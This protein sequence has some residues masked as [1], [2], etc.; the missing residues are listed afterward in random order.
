MHHGAPILGHVVALSALCMALL[1]CSDNN[2]GVALNPHE[3][4]VVRSA[5]AKVEDPSFQPLEAFKTPGGYPNDPGWDIYGWGTTTRGYCR[6]RLMLNQDFS[7]FYHYTHTGMNMWSES[8]MAFQWHKR[9]SQIV[10]ICVITI[11]G[12]VI[13]VLG[14]IRRIETRNRVAA[15]ESEKRRKA[16]EHE[17]N[18]NRI[19][20]NLEACISTSD[21]CIT[22]VNG[23]N[24]QANAALDVAEQEFAEGAFAPFWDAVE[25]AAN[26][27][28]QAD[29]DI[30]SLEKCS[31]GFA[32][33]VIELE[34]EPPAFR[35]APKSIPNTSRTSARMRE[36]VRAAQRN[37]EFASIYEQRKTNQLLIV[38][39]STLNEALT[40]MTGRL[41]ESIL[42]LS[43]S[44]TR[45]AEIN[46]STSEEL[47]ES[48]RLLQADVKSDGTAQRDHN[49]TVEK[50][51]DNIQRGR[52]PRTVVP[53]T[54][55]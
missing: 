11:A 6:F 7:R 14:H 15:E 26:R 40:T 18:Q 22:S 54:F 2:K 37:F 12:F 9:P 13:A 29:A 27:L 3:M 50:I 34:S 30:R 45:L 31:N 10:S 33:E 24:E 42:S 25:R 1:G 41:E 4:A 43:D 20:Q 46:R 35:F 5:L 44:I 55:D 32:K 23:N 17:A 16:I 38:G 52:K 48:V 8:Y 19:R 28:A 53:K 49:E 39:F 47:I 36:I 51:L 21:T